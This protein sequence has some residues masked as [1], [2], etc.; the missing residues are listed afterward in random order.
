[1]FVNC[2]VKHFAI[3]LGVVVILLF[4]VMDVLS[5]GGNS[6]LDG[7]PYMVGLL[8]SIVMSYVDFIKVFI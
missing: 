6:L 5:V 1:M 4:N 3:F 2:L 8:Q 7:R